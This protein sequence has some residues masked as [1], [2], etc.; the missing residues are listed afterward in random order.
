MHGGTVS[1]SLNGA[2]RALTMN[3]PGTFLLTSYNGYTGG[4]TVNGGTLVLNY[5]GVGAITAVLAGGSNLTI[6]TAAP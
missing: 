1:A 4:T 6:T 2:R 5:P 3:G